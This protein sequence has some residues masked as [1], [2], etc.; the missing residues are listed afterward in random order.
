MSAPS[1]V[2]AGLL[3]FGILI[4]LGGSWLLVPEILSPKEIGLAS[5]RDSAI[6]LAPEFPRA[7]WAA[8]VAQIRG[9]LWAGAAFTDSGLLWLDRSAPLS[10]AAIERIE[11]ARSNAEAGLALAP[12]NGEAWLFLAALPSVSPAG[13]TG[14][15]T[16][17]AG[18]SGAN[19]A[20][21]ATLLEMSYFTAP[22]DVDIAPRRLERAAAS[23]ALSDP[24]L[25]EFVKADIRALLASTPPLTRAI[26][27]AY[28]NALPQN[29]SVFESLVMDVDPAFAQSLRSGPP[30]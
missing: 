23:S 11:R 5:D 30:K 15:G 6:A 20:R 24:D 29:Q 2:H 1:K 17:G 18:T 3:I 12:I 21:L 22:S 10:R 13:T 7:L 4:G 19:D 14:A 16:S 26:I 8:R 25:R 9:D 27:A 28:R